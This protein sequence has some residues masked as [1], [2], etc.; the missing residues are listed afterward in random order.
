MI[1]LYLLFLFQLISIT[2]NRLGDHMSCGARYIAASGTRRLCVRA[3]RNGGISQLLGNG[4]FGIGTF[5]DMLLESYQRPCFH[6]I[7]SSF[8]ECSGMA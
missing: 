3:V 2:T 5:K 8:S 1:K 6:N 4:I 7:C